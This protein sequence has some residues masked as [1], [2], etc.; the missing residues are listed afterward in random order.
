[1]INYAKQYISKKDI[2]AVVRTLKSDY[3]T[4]GPAITKFEKK[5]INIQIQNLQ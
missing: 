1:M 4:T 3:L 5:L 2:I